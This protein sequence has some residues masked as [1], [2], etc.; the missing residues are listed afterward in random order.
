MT[1]KVAI[2]GAG[3][4]GLTA[5]KAALEENLQAEVFEKS[6]KIGGIWRGDGL[7]WQN[8]QVTVLRH[9]GVFS[10]FPWDANS[11][12]FPTKSQVYRYLTQ[13]ADHFD[14]N[15]FIYFNRKVMQI[16][17]TNEKWKIQWEES[18]ITKEAIFDFLIL[19]TG[20]YSLPFRPN[21][22]GLSTFSG[23][24][25]HSFRY[26]SPEE[27]ANLKVLVVG[28]GE[29][30]VGIASEVATEY[31]LEK[32]QSGKIKAIRGEIDDF[33][34]LSKTLWQKVQEKIL[35]ANTF[36]LGTPNYVNNNEMA[37]DFAK[38]QEVFPDLERLTIEDYFLYK[39]VM[40]GA[41]IPG[42]YRLQGFKSH[43]ESAKNTLIET[44]RSR[45]NL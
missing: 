5:A 23:R 42:Q 17:Q 30:G 22:K 15:A 43:Y 28:S 11:P 25:S 18:L 45:Q 12:D 9:S 40:Q 13:Y 33:S 20:K 3:V 21:L 41:L 8:M 16:S 27:F 24:V 26:R 35:Y 29:S 34:Y 38:K 7:A 6:D 14:L 32:I 37:D 44:D 1:K 31:Y 39:I 10:D 36:L 19:A 2:I 4:A